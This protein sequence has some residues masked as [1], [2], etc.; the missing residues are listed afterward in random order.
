M[1]SVG[2]TGTI[3][4]NAHG[5]RHNERTEYGHSCSEVIAAVYLRIPFFWAM[6]LL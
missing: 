3:E 4:F 1:Q 6:T 5:M 2:P